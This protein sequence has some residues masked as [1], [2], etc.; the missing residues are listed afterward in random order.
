MATQRGRHGDAA[1]TPIWHNG[2][3][4]FV[5]AR[6]EFALPAGGAS[7][8]VAHVTAQLSP[9]LPPDPAFSSFDYM[10]SIPGSPASTG[11]PKT[12][13]AGATTQPKLLGAYIL[14]MNGVRCGV[15]PGRLL[16]N[17]QMV[18][19]VDL[20]SLARR[21][22]KNVI[23]LEG[24]FESRMLHTG[25]GTGGPARLWLELLDGATEVTSTSSIW[26]TFNADS[27]FRP[28]GSF[29][30]YYAL[31]N[32]AQWGTFPHEDIDMVAARTVDGW[33][34]PGYTEGPGWLPA[35]EQPPFRRPLWRKARPI[36]VFSRRATSVV[37]LPSGAP[38]TNGYVLR[39]E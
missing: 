18:D 34:A 8:L 33:T 28:H 35:R 1:I 9:M 36:S 12:D 3:A 26:K 11:L 30:S 21:G 16:N 19:V 5:L 17:S 7:P 29:G 4:D 27:I 32:H 25:K 37:A 31:P 6:A 14:Y 20:S 22:E 23:A 38:T 39:I 24:F 2:T 15:G 10:G 13:T